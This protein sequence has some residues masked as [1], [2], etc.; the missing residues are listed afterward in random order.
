MN[1]EFLVVLPSARGSNMVGH[2]L[3]LT[4]TVVL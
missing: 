4:I 1:R 2:V 3:I